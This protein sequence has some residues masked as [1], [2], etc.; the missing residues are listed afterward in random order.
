M[1][2]SN[3]KQILEMQEENYAQRVGTVFGIFRIDK[4][5]YNWVTRT[6]EWTV[7]CTR[8]GHS[9]VVPQSIGWDWQRGKGRS[10]YKC[11]YCKE[12]EKAEEKKKKAKEKEAAESYLDSLLG[13]EINGWLIFKRNGTRYSAFCQICGNQRF[14]E[15]ATVEHKD[16]R[17]C[18]HPKDFSDP[19]YI[20]KRYGHLTVLGY[21]HGS[22]L[23]KCDCGTVKHI[24]PSIAE[25]GNNVTCGRPE[26]PYYAEN[27]Y[28]GSDVR[29]NGINTEKNCEEYLRDAGYEVTRTPASGDY[30]IDLIAIGKDGSRV[31]IQVKNNSKTKTRVDVGAVQ[32]AFAGGHFYDCQKYVV[33]SY[34]G[35]TV[36]AKTLADKLGV[37]LCDEKCALYDFTR[38]KEKGTRRFWVVNGTVELVTDTFR[39]NGWDSNKSYKFVDKTYEEVKQYYDRS[40]ARSLEIDKIKK[41][42]LSVAY[43]DYRMKH[44]GMTFEEAVNTP[45]KPQG[46]P[47]KQ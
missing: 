1:E 18:R 19:K 35:Y 37:M 42:G 28:V 20:G 23:A 4:V 25:I 26:C 16:I 24:K 7:T 9:E 38:N 8:C 2:E 3:L 11:R 30:G 41:S 13:E 45:K 47:R 36:Q 12:H 43:V 14:I 44:M 21:E 32:E 10:Q 5:E 22:F 40:K 33:I 27:V 46:R 39:R 31:G 29:K 17:P 34:T 15:K 6:Q